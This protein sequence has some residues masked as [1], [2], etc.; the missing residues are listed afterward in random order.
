MDADQ[1]AHH[2]A[3]A[4]EMGEGFGSHEFSLE[5]GTGSTMSAKNAKVMTIIPA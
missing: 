4:A 3:T 5:A 1:A 2:L